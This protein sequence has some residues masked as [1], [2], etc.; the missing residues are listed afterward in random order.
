MSMPTK[1]KIISLLVL[2]LAATLG[3]YAS[4]K[5]FNTT[6]KVEY[7]SLLAYPNLKTF[8]GFELTDKQNKKITI[9]DF[10]GKWTLLFFGF[11]SCPDVCPTT[12]TDLQSIYKS[13]DKENLDQKPEVLFISV[14]PERDTPDKLKNYINFF[15][16]NFNA[17]TGDIGSLLSLSSQ[18]GVAFNIEDHEPNDISY[19]V[20]H[21]AA[22]FLI[23][24]KKQIYGIFQ[25][26][27]DKNKIASDLAIL[28]EK[29]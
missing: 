2:L 8:S 18:I 28:M 7:Q 5:Y 17:A 22:L 10:S 12:L 27:H 4:N 24:P 15:N 14:D 3:M 1:S 16:P 23:N 25:S 19:N 26:P 11:T 9:E 6:T 21:T 20:D 13:L 29:K